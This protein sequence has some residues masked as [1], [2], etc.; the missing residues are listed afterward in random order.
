MV[1]KMK[2]KY[3]Y[4]IKIGKYLINTWHLTPFT[5]EETGV[6]VRIW[7]SYRQCIFKP[8]LIVAQDLDSIRKNG[9]II[10]I[11]KRPKILSPKGKAIKPKVLKQLYLWIR[12]NRKALYM[13]WSEKIGLMDFSLD[14]MKKI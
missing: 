5:S 13:L 8:F 2:E 14:L 10:S 4:R 12:L 6:N 11:E 1:Q 9:I 3:L 7:I